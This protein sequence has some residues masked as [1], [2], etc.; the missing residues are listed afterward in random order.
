MYD[1]IQGIYSGKKKELHGTGR[2]KFLGTYRKGYTFEIIDM[3]TYWT[4]DC[5]YGSRGHIWNHHSNIG[6]GSS[7][8]PLPNITPDF[9]LVQRM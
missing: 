1:F 9:T 8:L 4:A 2:D 6:G 5:V 3:V 7:P